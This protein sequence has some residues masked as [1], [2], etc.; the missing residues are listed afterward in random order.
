M[1]GLGLAAA[2]PI[3]CQRRPVA[4]PCR[5]SLRPRGLDVDQ[6]DDHSCAVC[7]RWF[8]SKKG[9]GGHVALN[10][11][12]KFPRDVKRTRA[13]ACKAALRRARG[14]RERPRAVPKA[15]MVSPTLEERFWAK[16]DRSGGPE[17][18]WPWTG[19]RIGR[20]YGQLWR[21]GRHRSATH[22]SLA[23]AG[24]PVPTGLFACHRCDNPP[25]VNPAHLFHGSNADNL[26]DASRKDRLGKLTGD[27]VRA[28]RR[29]AADGVPRKVSAA[30]HG[31]APC[32]IS[33]ILA[34][35]KR[36]DA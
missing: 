33:N 25:C 22:V 19:T 24:R 2:N 29:E 18:C 17:A 12:C 28:I 27:Q 10:P 5:A 20:G 15:R 23:I 21:D 16:V 3:R 36:S 4:R 34:G 32:T 6:Y 8:A 11:E 13:I 31:V 35:R 14:R 1:N 30:R 7:G 26:A 9:I